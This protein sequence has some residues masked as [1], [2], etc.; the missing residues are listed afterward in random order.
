MEP[1][2][3]TE[4]LREL[5]EILRANRAAWSMKDQ[6]YASQ[7]QWRQTQAEIRARLPVV[8][9][10]AK[11][12]DPDLADRISVGSTPWEWEGTEETVAE[13]IG[14]IRYRS[15]LTSIPL[16]PS[17]S[18]FCSRLH[19]GVWRSARSSWDDADYPAAL[20]DAALFVFGSLLPTKMACRDLSGVELVAE[21]FS[22]EPPR[23]NRARLRLPGTASDTEEWER[24]HLGM[25]QFGIGCALRVWSVV[26]GG[27]LDEMEAAEVLA[28][29]SSF[30]RSVER[31][32]VAHWESGR[33]G[34][35]STES[36]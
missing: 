25:K 22:V 29:L 30:A 34:S 32:H 20:S 6:I 10:I 3:A 21:A 13:L 18:E 36:A 1:A 4:H 9:A 14:L 15:D 12:L 17:L 35:A 23:P 16:P 11:E 8:L 27:P 24:A 31:S 5:L 28:A 26:D 19:P 2:R 7:V 33:T